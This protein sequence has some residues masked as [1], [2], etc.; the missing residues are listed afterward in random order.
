MIAKLSQFEIVNDLE[1]TVSEINVLKKE[2]GELCDKKLDENLDKLIVLR[3]EISARAN[4]IIKYVQTESNKLINESRNIERYFKKKYFTRKLDTEIEMKTIE[5]RLTLNKEELDEFK[6]KSL[7]EELSSLKPSLSERITQLKKTFDEDEFE[8]VLKNAVDLNLE[9]GEIRQK[10]TGVRFNLDDM[11]KK[12][13]QSIKANSSQS[14]NRQ[15]S[16]VFYE[17]TESIHS[18]KS[19]KSEDNINKKQEDNINKLISKSLA[20]MYEKNFAEAINYCNRSNF[21]F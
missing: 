16:T 7:K 6:L 21:K 19:E 8:F 20:C 9:F 4:E 1:E 13:R 11:V 17:N 12:Y 3:N 2:L 10:M 18:S 5:L 14:V 15:S